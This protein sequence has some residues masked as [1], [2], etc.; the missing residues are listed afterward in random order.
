MKPNFALS[1]SFE[2]ISLMQRSGLGW[3]V[4]GEVPL[5]GPDLDAAMQGLRAKMDAADPGAAGQVKLVIPGEQIR[6]IK[7]PTEGRRNGRLRRAIEAA[8]QGATPYAVADLNYDISQFGPRTFVAAVARETLQEA[9]TFATDK[10]FAPVG[11]VAMPPTGDF[12]GEVFF[13]PTTLAASLLN[14]HKVERDDRPVTLVS[15]E[16]PDDGADDEGADQD[17][18]ALPGEI[19]PT[20]AATAGVADAGP[21]VEGSAEGDAGAE[22]NNAAETGAEGAAD[23]QTEPANAGTEPA[24]EPAPERGAERGAEPAARSEPEPL[25]TAASQTAEP[26]AAANTLPEPAAESIPETARDAE[27]VSELDAKQSAN[28]TEG[29]ETPE[30]ASEA[31]AASAATSTATST[32]DKTPAA[33]S[34]A[35]AAH[36]SAAPATVIDGR[37][38]DVPDMPISTRA[39]DPGTSTALDGRLGDVPPAPTGSTAPDLADP[40]V[41]DVISGDVPALSE[42]FLA[43][44]ALVDDAPE[45]LVDD[46]P[47]DERADEAVSEPQPEQIDGLPPAPAGAFA[48]LAARASTAGRKDATSEDAR[49]ASG[50]A[51]MRAQRGEAENAAPRLDGVARDAVAPGALAAS[52]IASRPYT[53]AAPALSVTPDATTAPDTANNALSGAVS[54]SVPSQATAGLIASLSRGDLLAPDVPVADKAPEKSG[55]FSR[56]RQ[57]T[58]NI[59]TH[60]PADTET[61]PE[62][63]A[64]AAPGAGKRSLAALASAVPNPRSKVVTARPRPLQGT[65]GAATVADAD[66]ER[67]RM[68][69]FGAR[70]DPR[71]VGGKPRFLGL[72]LTAALLLF[73]AG[74]AAWA[75]VFLDNGLARF[76]DPDRENRTIASFPVAIP[77]PGSPTGP[78]PAPAAEPGVEIAALSPGIP[79]PAELAEPRPQPQVPLEGAVELS[80]EE[81]QTT[82]AATGIWQRAPLAPDLP[83]EVALEDVYVASIDPSVE[84]LDA[85]AL[86]RAMPGDA[87]PD[88]PPDPAAPGT[89]FTLDQRG[90]VIARPEGVLSPDGVVVYAGKPPVLPRVRPQDFDRTLSDPQ[91]EAETIRLAALRPQGRPGDLVEQTERATLGGRSLNELGTIRPAVRPRVEKEDAEAESQAATALAPRSVRAPINRPRNF[92]AVVRRAEERAAQPPPAETQP[93]QT[94]SAAAVAPLAVQP[95]APSNRSVAQQA[96]VRNA[97]NLN[98]V[99]LIGVYGKP[100][101]RRAL[102]RLPNGR[103]QKVQVGD[104]IEGGRV[105]AIGEDQLRYSRNGRDVTLNMPNG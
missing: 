42:D 53:G 36:P 103:Y 65:G 76:F 39:G 54:G 67:R 38:D 24:P 13:G 17:G 84:Q 95:G 72:M 80:P 25:E 43:P 31:D 48:A 91:A 98:R 97:I 50:F 46:A 10:H 8:L 47:E 71:A 20:A 18:G 44:E 1:L 32:D 100:S 58:A 66:D 21:H 16:D 40:Q 78:A 26:T 74:V 11:F 29:D 63:D 3:R 75:S 79:A 99:N 57:T 82:Y 62:P 86:P 60:D 52:R 55:F 70:D 41:G 102:V 90:L 83:A 19:P 22:T 4:L 12:A 35:V 37:L 5:D 93:Q 94:A 69:V 9:E 68:T 61:G 85:V 77:D 15:D 87:R 33:M 56:R 81:A 59:P 30:R 73:L 92:A 23:P 104:R 2:G 96:T 51:S 45:A 105:S 88:T 7:L 89:V 64:A 28:D 14:G 6:Y 49:P 27:A 34:E 101:S